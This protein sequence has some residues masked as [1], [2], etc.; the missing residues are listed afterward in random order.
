MVPPARRWL[1]YRV[2]LRLGTIDVADG[3]ATIDPPVEYLYARG[4]WFRP[5]LVLEDG[6]LINL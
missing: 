5:A 3:L 1:T 2:E 6:V 4:V